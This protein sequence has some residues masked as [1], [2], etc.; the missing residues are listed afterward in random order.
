M[1]ITFQLS[2][3]NASCHALSPEVEEELRRRLDMIKR[4]EGVDLDV[5]VLPDRNDPR[6]PMLKVVKGTG[7]V[8]EKAV[9]SLFD[10]VDQHNMLL[11]INN[12]P[13]RGYRQVTKHSY[14]RS[15]VV[16]YKYWQPRSTFPHCDILRY[17]WPH[18]KEKPKARY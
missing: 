3:G 9:T 10:F 2:T 13:Y 1:P 16:L 18:D 6:L 11:Q 4:F 8:Y 12:L 15:V 7:G 5:V 17:P 14:Q